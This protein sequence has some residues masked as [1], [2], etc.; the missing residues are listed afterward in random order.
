[1][2]TEPFSPEVVLDVWFEGRLVQS[3]PLDPT[4]FSAGAAP[5]AEGSPAPSTSQR[6]NLMVELPQAGP[7]RVGV[8]FYQPGPMSDE[9]T[10]RTTYYYDSS[11]SHIAPLVGRRTTYTYWVA[12]A[13]PSPDDPHVVE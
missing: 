2:N 6:R 4:L 8:H 5:A 9:F 10:Q 13:P 3:I 7:L 11:S 12:P 1:M